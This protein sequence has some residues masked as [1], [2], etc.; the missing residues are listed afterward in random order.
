[1]IRLLWLVAACVSTWC[2][3]HA[4]Q[5]GFTTDELRSMIA[6]VGTMVSSATAAG[7]G[8]V[9]VDV[10]AHA[11]AAWIA[12]ILTSAMGTTS[13]PTSN[14]ASHPV[15]RCTPI[16]VGVR[17]EAHEHADSVRRTIVVNIAAAVVDA[18]GTQRVIPLAEQRRS[19]VLS[20]SQ[21]LALQS[22]QHSCTWA[23][24]PA[25]ATSFW[26]DILE[27]AVFVGAA[28]VTTVLFFTVRSQ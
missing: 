25:P 16:D 27:P 8:P 14:A 12:T 6:S 1:M 11:D 15:V 10:V 7:S 21:A 19:V 26:Q 2:Q 13:E 23:E 9:R 22:K 17:Y 24:L 3:A 18:D 20:R 28:V 5:A 4:Q